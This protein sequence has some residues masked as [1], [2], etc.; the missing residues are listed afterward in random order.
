MRMK[1]KMMMIPAAMRPNKAMTERQQSDRRYLPAASIHSTRSYVRSSKHQCMD[2]M[3]SLHE[4]M[5]NCIGLW[6]LPEGAG[7]PGMVNEAWWRKDS[8]R[9]VTGP[10][11][12]VVAIFDCRF[13]RIAYWHGAPLAD[14]VVQVA[15][16]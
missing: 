1:K 3:F 7:T 2:C 15:S 9:C 5:M 14:V 12:V 13:L 16:G 8:R 4:D 11:V 10:E 6:W